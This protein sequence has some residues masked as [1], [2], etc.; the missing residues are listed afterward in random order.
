[1][2]ATKSIQSPSNSTLTF[3]KLRRAIG[4][5][6]MGLPVVLILLSLLPYFDTQIQPSISD[7]YYTHFREIFVGV[8]CA[9]SLFLIRYEGHKGNVFWKNDDR[10]TNIAGLMALGV[11][12]FPTNRDDGAYFEKMYSLVP[13][14]ADWVGQL[15]YAFAAAFFVI[16]AVMSIKVFTLGQKDNPEVQ[17][18]S[19]NENHIYRICGYIM[20]MCVAFIPVNMVVK[21][22]SHTTLI[23]ETV[24]LF[25]FGISWLIKGRALGDKGRIGRLL[26]RENN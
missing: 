1:M 20:L 10:M 5:L 16:L 22:H 17:E 12:I 15:H 23:M 11:A 8:L 21:I 24:A 3:R 18:S 2:S 4:W 7:Y 14:S 25:A 26:Y 19:W 13:H 6:G 9:V